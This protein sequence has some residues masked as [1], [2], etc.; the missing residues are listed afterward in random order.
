MA[1]SIAPRET[2]FGVRITGIDLSQELAADEVAVLRRALDDYVVAI[3]PDQTL[4]DEEQLRFSA[5][6]GPIETSWRQMRKEMHTLVRNQAVS[7][8]GNV[9]ENGEV[10]AETDMKRIMQ[11][12]NQLWHTDSSYRAPSARYTMLWAQIVPEEG[13][14]TQFADMRAAYDALPE[15]WKEDIARLEAEHSL[16]RTFKLA[17]SP[18]LSV[19]EHEL[20]PPIHHPLVRRHEDSGRKSLYIGSHASHIATWPLK[21]GRELLARLTEFATQPQFVY[22]HAWRPRDLVMWDNRSCLHR[23]RPFD[24]ATSKRQ[25]RRTTISHAPHR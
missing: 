11:R 6:F 10:I 1:I 2:G 13:G 16:D 20:L 5:Y 15:A 19:E 12:G 7:S 14:T 18:G 24:V 8:V 23:G 9:G 25:L 4:D 3:F 17:G 22:E 21:E